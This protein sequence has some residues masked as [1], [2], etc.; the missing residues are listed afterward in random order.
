MTAVRRVAAL[1]AVTGA[2]AAALYAP[3]LPSGTAAAQEAVAPLRPEIT[4]APPALTRYRAANFAFRGATGARFECSLD[5]AT[6]RACTSP[7]RYEGLASRAH[8]FRVRA[9]YAGSTLA[10]DA[11]AHAWTVDALRPTAAMVAVWHPGTHTQ[12]RATWSTADRGSGVANSD[13]GWRRTGADG[14]FLSW[15]LP[16]GWQR[17][18]GDDVRIRTVY[19]GKTY[20][21]SARARDRAGNVS[22]WSTPRCRVALREVLTTSEGFRWAAGSSQVFGTRGTLHTYS[23]EVQ[24]GTSF[25]PNR[26]TNLVDAYLGNRRG[27]SRGSAVRLQRV[28]PGKARIRVLLATPSTVDRY[29]AGVAVTGGYFSCWN[30]RFAL[31]NANRWH[32]GAEKFRGTLWQ[33]RGYLLNHEVG[34]ALG[35]RHRSCP[36]SGLPAPVMMQQTKGS[37]PCRPNPW[38]YS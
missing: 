7:V 34:H 4:R 11:A 14:T 13:V 23:A 15:L 31:I 6:Y 8:G 37:Y 30:G 28:P 26:F 1:L 21:F 25:S 32:D 27:W 17:M 29:C 9:T 12:L 38:P 10:S 20:C 35:N 19:G 5:G 18:T 24:K 22:A 33:Y 3:A 16:A 2:V 36:G